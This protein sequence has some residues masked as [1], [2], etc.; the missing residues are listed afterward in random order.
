MQSLGLDVIKGELT[1]KVL[2]EINR[3]VTPESLEEELRRRETFNPECPKCG[4]TRYDLTKA[5]G[6]IPTKDLTLKVEGNSFYGSASGC[7]MWTKLLVKTIALKQIQ[8]VLKQQGISSRLDFSDVGDGEYR[9][10][11]AYGIIRK[12]RRM[13]ILGHLL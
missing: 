4:T 7:S 1:D 8:G 6:T 13:P 9:L 2:A 11:V 12:K 10:L 3:Q 5:Y